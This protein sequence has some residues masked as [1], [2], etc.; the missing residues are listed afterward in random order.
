MIVRLALWAALASVARAQEEVTPPA[1]PPAPALELLEHARL[2]QELVAL[3]T[4]HPGLVQRHKLGNSRAGRALE[5]LRFAGKGADEEKAR[6][7]LLL[8]ANLDGARLY[9]SAVALEHARAL[10]SGYGSDERVTALLDTTTVWIVPRANPDAAEA[11]FATPRHEQRASGPGVDDDR[12]GRSGEDP[13]ADVNGDGLVSW[14]RVVDPDGEWIE[15]PTDARA[16]IKSDGTKGERGKYKLWPEGRDLDGDEKVAEDAPLDARVE[17][18]FPAGWEEHTREAGAFPTDE[19]ETRALVEFVVGHPELALVVVYDAQDSLVGDVKSVGDDAPAVK[20]VPPEGV[21]ESDAKLLGE[22]AKRYR[23]AT[24]AKANAEGSERGTF[25]RWCYEHRGLLTLS[26]A[27]WELPL[28][29]PKKEGDAKEGEK[30]DGA[31][32]EGEEKPDENAAEKPSET[33]A[34]AAPPAGGRG[35]R[36]GRGEGGGAG[37][38]G[39]KKDEP[40]P[41]ED[42]KRLKWIDAKGASEAWRFTPWAPFEHPELGPVEIGGLAPYARLEPPADESGEIARKHF[43]WFVTLGQELPRVEL[44]ECE[45][46]KLGDGLWRVTAVLQNDAYLPLLTRSA[47]RSETIRPAK[48]VLVLPTAAKLVAGSP[49]ELCSDLP[50]SGGRKE[51]TWLVQGP[52]AMEL[53]VR[54]ETDHAGHVLRK[55]EVKP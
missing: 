52:D 41:A 29:E 32:A 30:K 20:R 49:Q 53:A 21:L 19:P 27:L 46:E 44:A 25:S 10:A 28:E 1:P 40:K 48:V 7:A 26:T 45:R 11:R 42:A 34:E 33:P 43:D 18:N 16:L 12:D 54:V 8:V 47:R 23:E 14:M 15:D 39:I 31:P 24:G 2:A 37:V 9:S 17:R 50:G 51:Y 4:A 5:A 3:E 35:G 13:A 38:G 6:P 22:L 55:A 36:R